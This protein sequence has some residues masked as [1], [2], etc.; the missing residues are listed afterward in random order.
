[1]PL[2]REQIGDINTCVANAIK[3]YL[4]KEDFIELLISRVSASIIQNVYQHFEDKMEQLQQD[5][6]LLEE[7]I[8]RLEQYS[9]RNNVRLFGIQEMD[10]ENVEEKVISIFKSKL[11]INIRAEDIDRMHRTGKK[12]ANQHRPII[13]KFISYRTKQLVLSNKKKFKGTGYGL[14]EDLTAKRLIYFKEVQ[15]KVGRKNVWT[16]DGLIFI[17]KD[18]QRIII[19]NKSDLDKFLGV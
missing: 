17:Q 5:K 18:N 14:Q 6:Q 8:D 1:M 15:R 7:K 10:N 16:R 9:R 2:T 12:V 13:I 19:N 4:Q 11:N 3:D